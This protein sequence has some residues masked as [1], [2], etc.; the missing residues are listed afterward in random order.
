MLL[1]Q[2]RPVQEYAFQENLCSVLNQ[3]LVWPMIANC[4]PAPHIQNYASASWE[5]CFKHD[6]IASSDKST[7]LVHAEITCSSKMTTATQHEKQHHTATYHNSWHEG[8]HN[9][10]SVK[11]EYLLQGPDAWDLHMHTKGRHAGYT[12]CASTMYRGGCEIQ[13]QC[14]ADK[15]GVVDYLLNMGLQALS[16]SVTW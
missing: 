12:F 5:Y 1:T 16:K 7:C 11:S 8:S 13:L 15:L 4:T 10:C 14:Q 2:H 6:N 3:T 9:Y